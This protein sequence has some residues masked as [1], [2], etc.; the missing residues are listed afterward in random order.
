MRIADTTTPTMA[1]IYNKRSG[2]NPGTISVSGGN[3]SSS[4]PT[5]KEY[6]SPNMLVY[7]QVGI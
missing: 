2:S 6:E 1:H 3:K 7:R 4:E 5:V